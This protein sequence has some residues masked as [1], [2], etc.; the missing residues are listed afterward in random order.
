MK[1]E[2]DTGSELLI[3]SY[4]DYK[5]HFDKLKLRRTSIMLKTYTGKKIA[6]LG[7]LKVRVSC[8]NKKCTLDIY[9]LKKCG[10]PLI[11]CEWLRSIQL[12][13][14][15]IKAMQVTPKVTT[16]SVQDKLENVLEQSAQVFQ[17]GIGTLKHIKARLTIES[18]VQPKFHKARPVPYSVRQKVETE[19]K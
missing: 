12:N 19:L 10:V 8:E 15:S 7:K 2:L 4:K 18:N 13:W 6:P 5:G 11:G 9:V 3:I 14:Q 17:D 16:C 1:M